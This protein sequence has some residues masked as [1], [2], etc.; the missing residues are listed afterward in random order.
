MFS[1]NSTDDLYERHKEDDL[2]RQGYKRWRH[3]A[4]SERR[5]AERTFLSRA[6][7][8]GIQRLNG[9]RS[10]AMIGDL[11]ETHLDETASLDKYS[12]GSPSIRCWDSLHARPRYDFDHE[13]T[14]V[15]F[16]TA[17]LA[18]RSIRTV[19]SLSIFKGM[20]DCGKGLAPLALTQ[21]S[22]NSVFTAFL[23]VCIYLESFSL[24]IETDVET[25]DYAAPKALGVLPRI[26]FRMKNL[27]R[28]DLGLSISGRFN[29]DS[30]YTYEQVFPQEGRWPQLVDLEI[31]GLA[32]GGF[33]LVRM[34]SRRFPKLQHLCLSDIEL[35]DGS[36]EGVVEGMR[37][38]LHLQCL[39]LGDEL[40]HLRQRSDDPFKT[41]NLD[42]L[43]ELEEY[44]V[45]GGRHPCL[46]TNV[47][48]EEASN[49]WLDLCPLQERRRERAY[50]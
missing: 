28:L 36:W 4:K 40:G 14:D 32:I 7:T 18:L 45:Y 38:T 10:F 20:V 35:V 2:V 33:Q 25:G 42:M 17:I 16:A 44:V 26:L 37:L 24:T 9:V 22:G 11:W 21:W 6:L 50:H 12:S 31:V 39:S 47:P 30:C 1:E 8:R 48:A 5:T 15:S 43:H 34:L 19:A 41:D 3:Y 27:K 13:P 29:W 49:F 23:N 46:S